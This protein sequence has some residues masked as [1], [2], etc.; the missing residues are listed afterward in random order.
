VGYE[1]RDPLL[2]DVLD[3]LPPDDPVDVLPLYVAES[4]FTH[5]LARSTVAAWRQ[6]R[7]PS[8]PAPIRVLPSL[9]AERFAELEAQHVLSALAARGVAAGPEWAL[10]LAAHGTLL[11][12]ARG[13]ETGR[14]ETE[15][16]CAALSR[17]LG[18]HFGIIVNGWLNH[19]RGGRWTQPTVEEALRRVA[20]A[21]Y[22][23]AVYFPFGFSA[24]NAE[25]QLEGRVWLRT[26]PR[27][28]AVHLACL[29]DSAELAAAFADQVIG[30]A[31]DA[32][33]TVEWSRMGGAAATEPVSPGRSSP[34]TTR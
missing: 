5:D 12:P 34:R 2:P 29:N 20:Q 19:A 8:R 9:E 22:R 25:S 10:V 6:R 16:I 14:E 18:P 7:A 26:Q 15:R 27:I 17:Q 28:E 23:R 21:G 13:L 33:G 30:P 3:G 11:D 31:G 1:F 24:D 4:G 32:Q